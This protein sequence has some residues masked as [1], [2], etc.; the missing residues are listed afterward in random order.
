MQFFS[1]F[2]QFCYTPLLT[3]PKNVLEGKIMIKNMG[4]LEGKMMIKN[5][6]QSDRKGT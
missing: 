4:L 5:K 1:T 6:G 3:D 2:E